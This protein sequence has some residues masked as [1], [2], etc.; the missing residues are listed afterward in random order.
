MPRLVRGPTGAHSTSYIMG[1][2]FLS[3]GLN[4]RERDADHLPPSSAADKNGWSYMFTTPIRLSGADWDKFTF[5]SETAKSRQATVG[6]VMSVRPPVHLFFS[7]ELLGS[8]WMDFHEI[9]HLN[10]FSKTCRT[11]SSC[12]NNVRVLY[13]QQTDI[14]L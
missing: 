8:H 11:K 3:Q 9:W 6:F 14:H 5:L 4:Q 10:I 2:K 13:M 1:A 12:R 7:M